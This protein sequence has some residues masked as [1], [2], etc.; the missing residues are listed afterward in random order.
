LDGEFAHDLGRMRERAGAAAGRTIVYICNPNNPTGTLTA[1]AKVDESIESAD[2]DTYF[3]V[4]EAY[5]EYCVDPAYWSC[6]KWISSHP[7]V[8]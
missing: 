1:S 5:F 6:A 3:L 2:E 7:N 4:D 8:I